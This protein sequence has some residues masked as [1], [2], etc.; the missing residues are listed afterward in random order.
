MGPKKKPD[1]DD[2]EEEEEEEDEEEEEEEEEVKDVKKEVKKEEKIEK[3]EEKDGDEEEEEDEAEEDEN[4]EKEKKDQKTEVKEKEIKPQTQN[5]KSIKEEKNVKELKVQIEEKDANDE[6]MIEEL[7]KLQEIEMNEENK[8]EILAMLFGAKFLEKTKKKEKKINPDFNLTSTTK[9]HKQNAKSNYNL[10]TIK[11][12]KETRINFYKGHVD[13]PTAETHEAINDFENAKLNIYRDM[14][15]DPQYEFLIPTKDKNTIEKKFEKV[16]VENI[17]KKV[18]EYYKKKEENIKDIKNRAENGEKGRDGLYKEC[19][20]KPTL[21]NEKTIQKDKRNL[22]QFLNE[23]D[24]HQ[25][26][27][28]AHKKIIADNIEKKNK[29]NAY[30]KPKV[31][32]NSEKIVQELKLKNEE[33]EKKAGLRLYKKRN[34]VQQ[35]ILAKSQEVDHL[36]EAN[37]TNVLGKMKKLNLFD[38][39]LISEMKKK[40]TKKGGKEDLEYV[41]E[42]LYK[43][44]LDSQKEI[45]QKVEAKLTKEK[46]ENENKRKTEFKKIFVSTGDFKPQEKKKVIDE[47]K[48]TFKPELNPKSKELYA[49]IIEKLGENEENQ[50]EDKLAHINRLIM[51]KK[52]KEAE[53]EKQ[54]VDL[55]EKELDGCTFKPSFKDTEEYFKSKEQ[56]SH[57]PGQRMTQLYQIGTQKILEKKNVDSIDYDFKRLG[58]ECTFEPT[59]AKVTID[60]TKTEHDIYNDK[61]YMI[62][63]DRSKK[64]RAERELLKSVHSRDQI[65]PANFEILNSPKPDLSKASNSIKKTKS[66]KKH[67]SPIKN[68]V[69]SKSE[70]SVDLKEER[71]D[72]IPLLIIDVNI[73]P[74]EQEKIEVYDGDTAESLASKFSKEHSKFL[75]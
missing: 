41:K 2:N 46:D 6:E 27:F 10:E 9:K 37:K 28:E 63:Y 39:T 73:R 49:E 70:D 56:G 13:N 12:S 75:I 53:L 50:K 32:P 1:D 66:P 22:E 43:K 26:N 65:N 3:K 23:M 64:G 59:I 15:D 36:E 19:T 48:F 38:Q 20:F 31:D 68:D 33:S 72:G 11:S 29:E 42:K 35:K 40:K 54:K 55:V 52:K 74:G 16:K 25:K 24:A 7:K 4:E 67:K 34:N 44:G 61:S 18:E 21:L 8:D 14:K 62:Y 30:Y 57:P 71:K 45:I 58:K 17:K 51:K 69:Q 5:T 47:L 60:F